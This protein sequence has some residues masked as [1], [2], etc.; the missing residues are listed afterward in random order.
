LILSTPQALTADDSDSLYD[1]YAFDRNRA[2]DCSAVAASRSILW[3]PNGSL[4]TVEL[5]GASDPDGDPVALTITGV[6]QDEPLTRRFDAALRTDPA[7][8]QLRAHRAGR[9]DGR[10]YRIAFTASDGDASCSGTAKVAVPRRR[11]REAVD[12]APPSYDSLGP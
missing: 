7:V 1:L 5:G 10:V 4:R 2:P 11:G 6:T 12:S 8:V 3:P 9:G